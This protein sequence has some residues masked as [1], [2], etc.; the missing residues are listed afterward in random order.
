MANHSKDYLRKMYCNLHGKITT[1]LV[2]MY[3]YCEPLD[4]VYFVKYCM[5]CVRKYV[6]KNPNRHDED[7]EPPPCVDILSKKEW[8]HLMANKYH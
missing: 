4:A 7:A 8:N 1:H 6:E 5:S 2:R 3:H